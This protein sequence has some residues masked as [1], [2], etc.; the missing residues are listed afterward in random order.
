MFGN[1]TIRTGIDIGSTS[2]KLVR[3][4][5]QTRLEEITHAGIEPYESSATNDRITRAADALKTLMSRLDLSKHKLGRI[6]VTVGWQES[7]LQEAVTP[8]LNAE[9]LIRALPFESQKHMNLDG[10]A[11]PVL[12]GQLLG[13]A[14][15]EGTGEAAQ[16]RVLFAA[17]PREARDY[18]LSILARLGLEP[19]V[20]DLE[21][22][23]GLNELYAYLATTE[24]TG[25]VTGLVDLGGRHAAMHIVGHG[26][27]L[28]SRNLGPG[29]SLNDS[30]ADQERYTRRLA[31]KIQQTITYYRGHYRHQVER[32]YLIGGGAYADGRLQDL[33]EAVGCPVELLD[34][35]AN[36]NSEIRGVDDVAARGAELVTACGLCRW[37]DD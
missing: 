36:A 5:G 2:V 24:S 19:K 26:S 25:K 1:Q 17:I 29:S 35:L 14:H 31:D 37:G 15:K 10:V 3:G 16:S 13:A 7:M 27:G 12:D 28:L 23:A 8:P 21:P 18:T 34:A 22:L 32:L 6:A 33:S 30:A 4:T 11:D 9:D 20:V